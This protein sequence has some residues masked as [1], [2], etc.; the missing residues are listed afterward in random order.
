MFHSFHACWHTRF[1][2][3]Q[4]FGMIKR[5]YRKTRVSSISQLSRVICESTDTGMNQVQLAFDMGSACR[6]P[7]YEWKSFLSSTFRDLPSITKYHP[8]KVSRDNLGVV[9]LQEFAYSSVE[10]V[11]MS[12]VE[13][14]SIT[15][16]PME[17]HLNA[18][19]SYPL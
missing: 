9:E 3:D 5:K 7:C 8:F 18:R 10:T 19:Q 12:C 1:S 11:N 17:S 2:P 13:V 6:V 4:Y 15:K 14:V 16:K